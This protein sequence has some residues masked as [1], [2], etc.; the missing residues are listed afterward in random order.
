MRARVCI[1]VRR[2][3]CRTVD[4]ACR[5]H[6]AKASLA[7]DMHA[8]VPVLQHLDTLGII[9]LAA[10]VGNPTDI[11]YY[12]DSLLGTVIQYNNYSCTLLQAAFGI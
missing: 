9:N 1:R 11:Y 7:C 12:V 3:K 8:S 4:A 10:R 2:D 6:G 5:Q